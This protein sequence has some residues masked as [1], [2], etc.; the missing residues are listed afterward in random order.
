[1]DFEKNY[2]PHPL[3]RVI[4]AVPLLYLNRVRQAVAGLVGVSL[5]AQDVSPYPPG[6]YTGATPAVWLSGQAEYVL[7]G[8]RERRRYFHETLQDAAN[9]VSESVAAG[10]HP[11]LCMERDKAGAQIAALDDVGLEQS[12]LAYTPGDAVRLEVS[13]STDDILD[14]AEYF[15]QLTGGRPVLYG[16]GVNADNVADFMVL[17]DL[18]GVMTADGCRDPLRFVDLLAGAGRVMADR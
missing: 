18:A 7:V 3:I 4:L 1:M 13:R 9:K 2:R 17:S 10:I 5:A 8:H 6:S 16:G 11:I 14:A 15:S 12:I